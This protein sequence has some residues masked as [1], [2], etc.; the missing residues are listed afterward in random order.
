MMYKELFQFLLQHKE[1]PVPGIGTFLLERSPAVMDFPNKKIAPPSYSI[2]LMAHV[3]PRP[4]FFFTGLGHAL[5]ITDHEAII[6]FNDFIYNL[7]NQ[8]ANG[9]TIHWN[10][11]G[12]IN[13]GLTGDI[14]FIPQEKSVLETPVTAEK[15]IREKSEHMVRVG[16]DQK[17]SAEMT[18]MLNKPGAT[19]S[20]WWVP[21]LAMALLA[22][23]FIGWYF[24]EMGL[25]IS[26]TGNGMKLVPGEAT[27]SYK[28]IP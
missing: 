26:S 3:N 19:K 21:A 16:E 28:L 25:D 20:Y 17:T 12:E 6:R 24:S 22:V 23:M 2:A 7:K 15:V 4:R 5:G 1:L 18:D 8:M 13:Q 27:V 14:K 10:G 9:D 11:V